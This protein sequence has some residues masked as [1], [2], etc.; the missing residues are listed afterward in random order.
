[1]H[2]QT[3]KFILP[4]CAL[5]FFLC[6]LLFLGPDPGAPWYGTVSSAFVVVLAIPSYLA[7][8]SWLGLRK[9]GVILITLSVLP[10]LVEAV[11]VAT[12]F[13]YGGFSYSLSLGPMFLSSVPLVVPF[14]YLPIL[15]GAVTLGCRYSGGRL[16]R[17]VLLSAGLVVAA[18]LVIDPAAV[19]A[20]FWVW[21][22]PGL[23][24]AIPLSNF[25]GW[26]LTGAAYSWIF[27]QLSWEK[28]PFPCPPLTVAASLLLITS[29]WSGYLLR[30]LLV[31]PA[32]IGIAIALI[33]GR[34]IL[35]QRIPVAE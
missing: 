24:Y 28:S 2:L 29:L 32:A 23:Y 31:I 16:S 34:L 9:G 19:H 10:L 6:G 15:L 11:A 12:G 14:A 22:S 25:I 5:A 13:P 33:V 4:A 20:G 35:S 7:L 17:A 26:A 21:D 3:R 18:D 30:E 1:M 8:V 27:F